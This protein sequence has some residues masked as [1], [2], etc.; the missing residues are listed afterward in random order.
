VTDVDKLVTHAV[1]GRVDTLLLVGDLAV[2]GRYDD[3]TKL[4]TRSDGGPRG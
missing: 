3:T 2:W 4:I 1:R